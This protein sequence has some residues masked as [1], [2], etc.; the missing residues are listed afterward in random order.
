MEDKEAKTL[1]PFK[2]V[3]KCLEKVKPTKKCTGE[4]EKTAPFLS[5]L[6][7]YL[8]Y[9]HVCLSASPHSFRINIIE[10]GEVTIPPNFTEVI[11]SC[12]E[13][14]IFLYVEL[15]FRDG[16]GHANMLIIDK[17]KKEYERFEPHGQADYSMEFFDHVDKVL[18]TQL[19]FP[20]PYKYVSTLE[21]CPRHGP[22]R[23]ER[24]QT[25]CPGGGFCV[26]WS[27]LYAHLRLANPFH[28]REQVISEITRGSPEEINLLLMKYQTFIDLV[29]S[30][31]E[32]LRLWSLD[33]NVRKYPIYIKGQ[34]AK[35]KDASKEVEVMN[36][37]KEE[38]DRLLWYKG[39]VWY[40][41]P[42]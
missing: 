42:S 41:H 9:K 28:S 22:Q 25:L 5:R 17:N 23:F 29:V 26:T 4:W 18:M 1:P 39:V 3:S 30:D 19:K 16:Q 24:R 32:L 2:G 40:S 11:A 12:K 34:L 27:T 7:N 13:T 38:L 10:G 8:K 36:K 15:R 20:T 6:V 31:E 35:G 14:L 33:F 37:S 21:Y